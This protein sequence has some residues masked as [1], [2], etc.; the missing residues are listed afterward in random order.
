M[1]AYQ[2]ITYPALKQHIDTVMQPLF[3]QQD[4]LAHQL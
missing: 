2:A 1:Q 4:L 3:S